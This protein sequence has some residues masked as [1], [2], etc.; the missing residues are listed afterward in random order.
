MT[1]VKQ[2]IGEIDYVEFTEAIDKFESSGKW[3]AGTQGIVVDDYG[4]HKMVEIFNDLGETLDLPV[5]PEEKL[6]LI[7]KYRERS[8]TT[9]ERLR[10][11]VDELTEAQAE[12]ALTLVEKEREDPKLAA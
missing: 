7:T 4:D 11:L 12:R 8:K 9:K 10:E 5:V 6:K 1:T 3:P 2:T